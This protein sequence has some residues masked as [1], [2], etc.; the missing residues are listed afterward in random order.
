MKIRRRSAGDPLNAAA[1]YD[2]EERKVRES[3]EATFQERLNLVESRNFEDVISEL[4]E[5][6]VNQGQKLAERIDIAELKLY[7]KLISE[8]LDKAVRN[9]HRFSKQSF[10]DR[11][12]RHRVYAIVKKINNELEELTREV[13][14]GEKNNL[15]VL[16]RLDDIRGLIMD[17]IM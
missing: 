3:G 9:A 10:L 16:K 1:I 8:F 7:R 4:V 14:E 6:I 11:R 2:K 5:R 12:G 15:Q 17:I 13:L